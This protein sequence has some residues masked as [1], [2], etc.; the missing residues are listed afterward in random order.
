MDRGGLPLLELT[1]EF[2][3][4]PDENCPLQNWVDLTPVDLEA[5]REAMVQP[6]ID[7]FRED[8]RPFLS[9]LTDEEKVA[10][11]AE[12]VQIGRISLDMAI[13]IAKAEGIVL[14]QPVPE[15][16]VRPAETGR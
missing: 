13:R 12:V 3:E 10:A 6:R 11:L 14:E 4:G 16:G 9:R 7:K 15:E 2:M 5:E 1:R 8:A